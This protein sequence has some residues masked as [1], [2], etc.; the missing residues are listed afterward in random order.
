MFIK[1]KICFT[2]FVLYEIAAIT[3]L[4]LKST[5]SAMFGMNFCASD[6]KYFA[7]AIA[8]PLLVYLIWMWIREIIRIRRR[9]HFIGLAKNVMTGITTS[10][11]ERLKHISPN[12]LEQIIIVAILIGVKKYS[13]RHPGLRQT[14]DEILGTSYGADMEYDT[15]YTVPKETKPKKRTMAKRASATVVAKTFKK[16][17]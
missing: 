10:I 6:F 15:E 17:K 12:D 8:I 14:L 3:V 7:G 1:S 16:K 9:R 13:M 4:H 11:H 5:C 2:V